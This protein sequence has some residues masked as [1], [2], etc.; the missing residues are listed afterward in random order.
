MITKSLLIYGANFQS[1]NR[2]YHNSQKAL[3]IPLTKII[4]K[5]TEQLVNDPINNAEIE[6]LKIQ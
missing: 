4:L 6:N 3:R 1:Q 2:I 5:I